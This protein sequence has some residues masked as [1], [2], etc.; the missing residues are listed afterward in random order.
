[1]VLLDP[2]DTSS[3]ALAVKRTAWVA[4][5]EGNQ[6]AVGV[7]VLEVRCVVTFVGVGR[8]VRRGRPTLVGNDHASE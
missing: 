5:A 8:A 4:I 1:M 2:Q 7:A 6:Q 3:L